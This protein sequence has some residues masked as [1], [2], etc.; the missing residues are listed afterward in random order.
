MSSLAWLSVA[1]RK[2]GDPGS[3][4]RPQQPRQHLL[5]EQCLTGGRQVVFSHLLKQFVAVGSIGLFGIV[6]ND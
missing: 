4:C 2:E 3:L 6:T 5:L 1:I